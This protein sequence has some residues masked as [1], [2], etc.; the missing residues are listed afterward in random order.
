M[1]P[2]DLYFCILNGDNSYH[3]DPGKNIIIFNPISHWEVNHC[4]IDEYFANQMMDSPEGYLDY[5]GTEECCWSSHK[6]PVEIVKD[7]TTLGFTECK[8]MEEFLNELW[9]YR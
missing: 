9:S 4:L 6:S 3:E 5:I 1:K 7:L 2:S 8:P